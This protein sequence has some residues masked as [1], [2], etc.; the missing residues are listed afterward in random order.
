VKR[1]IK[2]NNLLPWFTQDHGTLPA[3]YLAS[4]EEFFQW[5]EDSKRNGFQAPSY[6]APSGKQQA[7]DKRQ[8]V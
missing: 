1:R 7:I 6:Q 8:A 5:L 3:S 4:C 2:H